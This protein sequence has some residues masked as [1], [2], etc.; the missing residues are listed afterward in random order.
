M[1]VPVMMLAVML[2]VTFA[3]MLTVMLVVGGGDASGNEFDLSYFR[4]DICYS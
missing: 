2:V 3:V 1:R 4:L